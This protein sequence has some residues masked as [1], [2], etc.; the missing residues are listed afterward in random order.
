MNKITISGS[1]G[2]LE[3][4]LFVEKNAGLLVTFQ[5]EDDTLTGTIRFSLEAGVWN[6]D[7]PPTTVGTS[8]PNPEELREYTRQ[9]ILRYLQARSY[10]NREITLSPPRYDE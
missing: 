3:P 10:V 2:Y 5:M 9:V 1:V 7:I 6:A 4:P 8:F